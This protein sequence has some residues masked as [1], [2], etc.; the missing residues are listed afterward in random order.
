MCV[1]PCLGVGA[2]QWRQGG[3]T[4]D[5]CIWPGRRCEPGR[6]VCRSHPGLARGSRGFQGRGI[7]AEPWRM[8][9]GPAGSQVAAVGTAEPVSQ[10]R[11]A[12]RP[13]TCWHPACSKQ[14]PGAGVLLSS[15]HAE[16]DLYW[17]VLE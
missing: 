10:G 8:T 5:I 2:Q 7:G 17:L 15:S 13:R 3:Y 4:G 9:R 11:M 1:G 12:V 16:V 6:C 14:C